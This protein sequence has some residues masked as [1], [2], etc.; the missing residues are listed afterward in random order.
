MKTLQRSRIAPSIA[1]AA[2]LLTFGASAA[3]ADALYYIDTP[4]LGL[5]GYTGPYINLS[6][7]LL[8]PVTA[9]VT[10]TSDTAASGNANCTATAP[11]TY[12]MGGTSAV[13]LNVA[14]SF[15]FNPAAI[16]FAPSSAGGFTSGGAGN[17]SEFGNF[18]LTIDDFDGFSHAADSISFTLTNT[19]GTWSNAA[20]V[21]MPNDKGYLAGSHV[22]VQ[23]AACQG[24]CVTGFAADSSPVPEPATFAMSGA[25]ILLVGAVI[26]RAKRGHA[27]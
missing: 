7:S 3:R 1:L 13:A 27:G 8:D 26:R 12:L 20:S 24:A 23:S 14:G 4:N 19:G 18:N 5:S 10:F 15:T 17:V 21:L 22:F 9:I 16:A 2:L 6:I 11:C 25:G